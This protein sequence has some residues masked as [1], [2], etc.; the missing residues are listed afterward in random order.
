MGRKPTQG[1]RESRTLRSACHRQWLFLL[2]FFF[3]LLDRRTVFAAC[4]A[5]CTT[6]TQP[7]L[8]R[9]TGRRCYFP[10]VEL[11]PTA[12]ASARAAPPLRR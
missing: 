12:L 1:E 7:Q 5:H 3:F 10:A 2:L 6:H 4:Q 8:R 9:R 11:L